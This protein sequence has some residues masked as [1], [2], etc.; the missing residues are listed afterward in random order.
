MI[1]T[2]VTQY[3]AWSVFDFVAAWMLIFCATISYQLLPLVVTRFER[4]IWWRVMIIL[5]CA[6]VWA[7]LAVGL[8]W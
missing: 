7:E 3:V 4:H 2:M 5:T 8:V 1:G 6:L